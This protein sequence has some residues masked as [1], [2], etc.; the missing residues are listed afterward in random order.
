MDKK[1]KSKIKNEEKNKSFTT[2]LRF[3][4]SNIKIFVSEKNIKK[5][6]NKKQKS[7]KLEKEKISNTSNIS[8]EQKRNYYVLNHFKAKKINEFYDNESD[9]LIKKIFSDSLNPNIPEKEEKDSLSN[10]SRSGSSLE[11]LSKVFGINS[12]L[13]KYKK[14]SNKSYSKNDID[15]DMSD[16]I[17]EKTLSFLENK[18]FL[19]DKPKIDKKIKKKIFKTLLA[20]KEQSMFSTQES[21]K[22]NKKCLNKSTNE[23]KKK[24]IC[25]KY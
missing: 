24:E 8:D 5:D 7:P 2:N 19:E 21:K 25:K 10:R 11:K 13:T 23:K 4:F 12:S 22:N 18:D 9:S 20:R 14:V 3:D 6:N 15:S 17:F 1:I 16:P